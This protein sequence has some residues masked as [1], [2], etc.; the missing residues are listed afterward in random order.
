MLDV[1]SVLCFNGIFHIKSKISEV[2]VPVNG[3]EKAF[4]WL[5][6]L[7]QEQL[8]THGKSATPQIMGS[9]M[10]IQGERVQSRSSSAW[11]SS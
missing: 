1:L 8:I 5:Q 10:R 6:L 9:G 7:V 11:V 2:E 3:R 4:Y